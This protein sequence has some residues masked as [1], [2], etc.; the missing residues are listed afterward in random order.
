MKLPTSLKLAGVAAAALASSS[1]FAEIALSEQFAISGYV[2]GS[3]SYTKVEGADSDSNADLDAM[4]LTAVAKFA[5][6]TVTT[7]LFA[8]GA[9][10]GD[11]FGASPIFLD[12][13]G[14]YDCGNGTTVTAGKYL[15][16]L[17]YEA[18]DIPNMLQISYA[19]PTA[20]YI[21]AYHTGI[22]VE[23]ST[24]AYTIG[25]GVSD[26]LYGPT[27]YKGDGDLDNGVGLEAY[28]T[29][30]AIKDFTWFAGLGYDSG[31]ASGTKHF[32]ADTWIQYVSGKFTYAAEYCYGST[33]Y[34]DYGEGG[35]NGDGYFVLG[36][37]KYQVDEKW[38][39]T[40]RLSAGEGE[41]NDDFVRATFAPTYSITKNL[42]VVGEYSYT[43]Y[44]DVG[45]HYLG[46]QA[47][48]K[49]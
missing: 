29:Y 34:K 7:S 31:D 18:F 3:A 6:V 24:D 20:A 17:G 39:A 14:T 15:S 25:F 28:F 46:V 26:S 30:K 33:D 44:D 36:L 8:F 2:A 22:K 21:P 47:R 5:P 41:A 45:V 48:F 11:G 12:A 43:D 19:N 38:A 4:K 42:D 37:V 1:L 13:Y 27:Y 9:G 10:S 16:W 23:N 40:F 49:F 32:V 35:G